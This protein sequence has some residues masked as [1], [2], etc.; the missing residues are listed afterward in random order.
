MVRVRDLF[1]C[2][3]KGIT[4]FL[5]VYTRTFFCD[6][7]KKSGFEPQAKKT[8]MFLTTNLF[9]RCRRGLLKIMINATHC[10]TEIL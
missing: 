6:K 8:G 10:S 1:T 2:T 3:I 5:I 7:E 4:D 9:G